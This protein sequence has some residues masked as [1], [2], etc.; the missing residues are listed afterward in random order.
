MNS[1]HEILA[2]GGSTLLN[3]VVSHCAFASGKD[4][5]FDM[6]QRSFS[7]ASERQVALLISRFDGAGSRRNVDSMGLRCSANLVFGLVG[8]CHGSNA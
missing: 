3:M 8:F 5:T 7:T 6:D 2:W 4:S 1:S